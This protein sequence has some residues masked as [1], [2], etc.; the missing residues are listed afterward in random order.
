LL[1]QELAFVSLGRLLGWPS[2]QA[3]ILNQTT[4]GSL[5]GSHGQVLC[6]AEQA[7]VAAL[8]G[9]DNLTTLDVQLVAHGQ[10]RRPARSRLRN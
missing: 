5:L 6:Q 4:I 8:I 3:Q 1:P 2:Q 10:S 7:E 9:H